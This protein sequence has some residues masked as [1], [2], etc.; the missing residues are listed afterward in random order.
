MIYSDDDITSDQRVKQP[1]L[2]LEDYYAHMNLEQLKSFLYFHKKMIINLESDESGIE[3][4]G[5]DWHIMNIHRPNVRAIEAV[6][7]ERETS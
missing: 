5:K 4:F 6:I 2:T 3:Q 1:A 7:K